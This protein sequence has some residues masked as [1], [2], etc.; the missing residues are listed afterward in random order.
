M[1]SCDRC[2]KETRNTHEV[3]VSA[4]DGKGQNVFKKCDFCEHCH[5]EYHCLFQ[6]MRKALAATA[7]KIIYQALDHWLAT[8]EPHILRLYTRDVSLSKAGESFFDKW[9]NKFKELF[10]REWKEKTDDEL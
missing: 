4:P 2:K 6:G 8:S 9:V 5:D 10:S 7:D 1:I 3:T